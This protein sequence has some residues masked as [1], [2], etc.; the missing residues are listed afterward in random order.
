M[1]TAAA[2]D[3]YDKCGVP[4]HADAGR[5]QSN[6]AREIAALRKENARLRQL[7]AIAEGK[8]FHPAGGGFAA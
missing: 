7:L 2:G 3:N 8:L 1:T 6:A 5:R 4:E